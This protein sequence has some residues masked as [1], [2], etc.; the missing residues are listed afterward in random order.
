MCACGND[1][2]LIEAKER[3]EHD[4]HQLARMLCDRHYG[5]G[6]DGLLVVIP[7]ACQP[8]HFEFR[9]FNPDGTEDGCGNGLRCAV[10]YVYERLQCKFN[11]SATSITFHITT[12]WGMRTAKVVH[13]TA[14]AFCIEVEMGVPRWHPIEL[15]M[16]VDGDCVIEY[17]ISVDGKRI[18]ITCVN[19]G[20]THAIIFWDEQLDDDEWLRLSRRL[21]IH[22]LFPKRTS[23]M[24]VHVTHP[25]RARV[26]SYERAVGE[27]LS[28]GTGA[29]AVLAAGVVAG[30]L[31]WEATI[32]FK[33]GNMYV[34]W[35]AN[36]S[37]L[38]R[39]DAVR[40]FNGCWRGSSVQCNY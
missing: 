1:F 13:N 16:L 20:S 18:P 19:T 10:R 36:R 29:C 40:V 23:I 2:V 34:M 33:G 26:R 7:N 25:R 24:W 32:V 4:W 8:T 39:G 3:N 21:E 17:P 15:P 27:T 14:D 12:I 28:C 38:L 5:I 31:D 22:P 11:L 35:D 9:M 37:L 6:A 30:Y